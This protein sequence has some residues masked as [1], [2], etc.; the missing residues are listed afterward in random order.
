[1][2]YRCYTQDYSCIIRT[3][4]SDNKLPG[5]SGNDVNASTVVTK[6][7]LLPETDADSVLMCA[8]SAEE[9]GLGSCLS[10]TLKFFLGYICSVIAI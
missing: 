7:F 4:T 6:P 1:M 5:F 2:L 3:V 10:T 9:A 8:H